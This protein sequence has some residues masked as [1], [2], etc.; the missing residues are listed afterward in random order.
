[1]KIA[2]KIQPKSGKARNVTIHGRPYAFAPIHDKD[3]NTHF[4][5][6]VKNADHAAVLLGTGDFYAYGDELAPKAT[7]TIEPIKPAAPVAAEPVDAAIQAEAD[8]LLA[9]SLAKISIEVGKVTSLAVVRAALATEQAAEPSRKTVVALLKQTL[10][11]A[12]AAGVK[13]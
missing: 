2:S 8:A 10:E 5:A 12:A 11:G 3:D 13:D 7:L 9:L 6:E 4:V 1:M